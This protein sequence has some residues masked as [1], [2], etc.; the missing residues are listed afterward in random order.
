[1]LI[2]SQAATS[3]INDGTYVKEVIQ[4]LLDMYEELHKAALT[5]DDE[6]HDE[7]ALEPHEIDTIADEVDREQA[8]ETSVRN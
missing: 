3:L 1:G 2:T 6:V 7:L 4:K 8:A 5:D